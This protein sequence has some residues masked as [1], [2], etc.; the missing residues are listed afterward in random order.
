MSKQPDGLTPLP[1]PIRMEVP[2][3]ESPDNNNRKK[4]K[5]EPIKNVPPP[6]RDTPG[7]KDKGQ[8]HFEQ[9]QRSHGHRRPVAKKKNQPRKQSRYSKEVGIFCLG[10]ICVALVVFSVILLRSDNALAVY[11]NDERIGYLPL[12]RETREWDASYVQEQAIVHRSAMVG[13]QVT[14]QVNEQVRLVPVRTGRGEL[15]NATITEVIAQVSGRFTYQ[16]VAQA[17]YV[18][19]ERIALMQSLNLAEHV[20]RHFTAVFQRDDTVETTI[21]GWALL[22]VTSDGSDLDSAEV[23][24]SRLDIRVDDILHYIVQ[25]GDSLYG[26]A[27]R[28]N[29]SANIMM[30]ENGLTVQSVPHP[31]D[32]IRIRTTR[33]FLTVRTLEETTRTEV[34]PMERVVDY[35]DELAAGTVNILSEGRDGERSFL[36]RST[37]VNGDLLSYEIFNEVI[38]VQP[39]TRHEVEGTLESA[40][41]EWR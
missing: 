22:A 26:I 13:P 6:K 17:I 1:K 30:Q 18:H 27:Y 4:P 24:I 20:A 31:G 39:I 15:V 36:V 8:R 29:V 5:R 34:I 21:D 41:A 3:G 37:F 19:G 9:A 23:A 7:A 33:P 10:L 14:I 35:D 25:P 32:I 16:I 28:H 38:T 12:N 2:R 40:A 11:L